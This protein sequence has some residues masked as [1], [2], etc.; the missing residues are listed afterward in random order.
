MSE[1]DKNNL[2][3]E[4]RKEIRK[5][6]GARSLSNCSSWMC[7]AYNQALQEVLNLAILKQKDEV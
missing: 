7:D 2:I 1:E 3:L 4:I 5:K 6:F